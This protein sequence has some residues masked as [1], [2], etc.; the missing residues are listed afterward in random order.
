LEAELQALQRK[1]S[2]LSEEVIKE[3]IKRLNNVPAQAMVMKEIINIAKYTSK[4][5][6]RYSSE[7]L[8]TCIL[9]HIHSPSMYILI[10]INEILPLPMV[11]TVK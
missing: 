4:H 9:M 11:R 2:R 5:S 7:W 6:R 10:A 1:V 8:L 3:H